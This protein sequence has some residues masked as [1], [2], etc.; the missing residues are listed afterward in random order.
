[1]PKSRDG[2]AARQCPGSVP[3]V[4]MPG[5]PQ[6]GEPCAFVRDVSRLMWENETIEVKRHT[7]KDLNGHTGANANENENRVQLK[8][9]SSLSLQKV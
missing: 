4:T 7:A 8:S 9:C 1:M 5:E 2:F 3:G 6:I